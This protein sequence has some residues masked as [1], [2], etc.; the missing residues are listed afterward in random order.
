MLLK[1]IKLELFYLRKALFQY[2]RP[3]KYLINK[4]R[5]APQILKQDRIFEKP[6][7]Q[8]NLSVHLLS[9]HRDL[10]MLIW[11]L[12]SFYNSMTRIGQLYIHSD[13]SLTSQDKATIY[14]F[15]PSARVIQPEYLLKKHM[16]QLA[17]YPFIRAFRQDH[18]E[19]VL[20][21]KLIDPYFISDKQRLL[22]I[23]SDLAWYRQPL[24]LEQAISTSKSLMMSGLDGQQ[25]SHV[26]F[27]NNTKLDDQLA[28]Y[29]SGIVLYSKDNFSLDTLDGYLA[30]INTSHPANLHFIEQ[31][32]YSYVLKN[33]SG[34][35]SDDYRI[36]LPCT[37]HTV[38]RHYTAPRRP[39]FYLEAL[40]ILKKS[41]L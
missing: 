18:P 17:Q 15:F 13:G 22:I 40:D 39:L 31:A 6:I 30:K 8:D 1:K 24:A 32:G 25:G 41:L 28:K 36:K 11:S 26:Y 29:N 12:A 16:P 4:F 14:K 2:Q 20:L 10:L 19:Y 35:S 21:K 34:L 27:K 9:C 38:M 33:L 3:F 5:L 37:H 23:D 7:S